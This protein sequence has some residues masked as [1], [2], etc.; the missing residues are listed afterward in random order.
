MMNYESKIIP[1]S[2]YA[3]SSDIVAKKLLG[4]Y[5]V[6][7]L[8]NNTYIVGK[9]VEVE[10]YLSADDPAAHNFVGQTERNKSLFKEE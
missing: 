8:D 6:R 4:Q 10:A 2:F 7:K 3:T 5:L 9:I 1:R